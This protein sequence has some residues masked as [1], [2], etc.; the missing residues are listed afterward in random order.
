MT[1]SYTFIESTVYLQLIDMV[2][3][4]ICQFGNVSQFKIYDTNYM[5]PTLIVIFNKVVLCI[6]KFDTP[7]MIRKSTKIRSVEGSYIS[8]Q[9][10]IHYCA[11]Y[12]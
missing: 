10:H 1:H 12:N 5:H 2:V 8:H 11:A 7:K 9:S 4:L 3:F 6:Y